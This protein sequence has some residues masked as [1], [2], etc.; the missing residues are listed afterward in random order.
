[1][2]ARLR[3]AESDIVISSRIRLAR[4]LADFPFIRRCTEQDRPAIEKACHATPSQTVDEW[5][6]LIYVDVADAA[7][8]RPAV[9][10]R[11][12]AHQP[13]A[14]RSERRPRRRSSSRRRRSA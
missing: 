12:A 7:D 9:P 13:R 5:Q 3:A 1:M 8:A 10:R 14:G 6:D 2:A 11:A 4:N